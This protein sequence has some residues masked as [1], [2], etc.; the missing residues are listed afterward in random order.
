MVN[1]LARKSSYLVVASLAS[2]ALALCQCSSDPA[3]QPPAETND[4]SGGPGV[5]VSVEAVGDAF[6]VN[7]TSGIR[8]RYDLGT[9]EWSAADS[10]GETVI[11]RAYA[12]QTTD[13]G[14]GLTI[15]HSDG[16]Q[17][18]GRTTTETDVT[19]ELGKGHSII[20]HSHWVANGKPWKPDMDQIFTFYPNQ[21][22][23][24]VQLQASCLSNVC[25]ALNTNELVPIAVGAPAPGSYVHPAGAAKDRRLVDAPWDNDGWA[26]WDNVDLTRPGANAS[27]TSW[28][29]T[30]IH[31]VATKKG[32]I[33]GSI[34]HDWWKT[35]IDYTVDGANG[36]LASSSGVGLAV[37]AGKTEPDKS[38][39]GTYAT[40]C[41]AGTHDTVPHASKAGA[42]VASPRVFVGLFDDWR[43]GLESFGWANNRVMT[44]AGKAPLQWN[45]GTLFGWMTYGAYKDS[46]NASTSYDNIAGISDKLKSMMDGGFKNQS[47]TAYLLLDAWSDPQNTQKIKD[48]AH[49]NG[50]KIG[51]YWGWACLLDGTTDLKSNYGGGYTY[52]QVVVKDPRTGTP[53]RGKFHD[54]VFDMTHPQVQKNVQWNLTTYFGAAWDEVKI[55]F[56]SDCAREGTHYDPAASG[57]SAYN[58][59]ANM[60]RNAAAANPNTFFYAS[61]AP[62]FPAGY[63]H[64]RRIACDAEGQLNDTLGKPYSNYGST[65]YELNALTFG[66]WISPS[67]FQYNDGDEL[68]MNR[69]GTT[70]AYNAY[71]PQLNTIGRAI[72]G[73]LIDSNDYTNFTGYGAKALEISRGAFTNA[74]VVE[75]AK[76]GKSFIPISGDTGRVVA[77]VDQ[78][79][80]ASERFYSAP[81]SGAAPTAADPAYLAV[82]NYDRSKPSAPTTITALDVGLR[83]GTEYG[84]YDVTSGAS[85]PAGRHKDAFPLPSLPAGTARLY[86]VY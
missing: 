8:F 76:R 39:A 57:T 83:A 63:T 7:T 20:V 9:G 37:T 55:D 18:T 34:D 32:V 23:F 22:F 31:N 29:V 10:N 58:A 73:T 47:G 3:P 67:L 77:A 64:S 71:W 48:K 60:V 49:A 54:Y 43:R 68:A 85:A 5:N 11:N 17:V 46:P 21:R 81:L 75:V 70:S 61:I 53:I 82:F 15:Q 65:E 56:L 2:L 42:T 72:T 14:A 74:S 19:D 86:Q 33:F 35:G 52:D 50:Q 13:Y 79:A 36:Q 84:L 41:V 24:T 45:G 26:R 12:S 69:W 78:G 80:Q 62:L 44:Q 30:A 4:L 66:W 40:Y 28:E 27:G 6:N 59:F 51:T 25:A 1:L 16:D 38:C